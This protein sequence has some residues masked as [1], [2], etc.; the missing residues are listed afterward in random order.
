MI[1]KAFVNDHRRGEKKAV[2]F[3]AEIKQ[4]SD[5]LFDHS[6]TKLSQV[7]GSRVHR[8]FSA[9]NAWN[10]GQH[11]VPLRNASCTGCLTGPR[12]AARRS[13]RRQADRRDERPNGRVRR[14]EHFSRI[15]MESVDRNVYAPR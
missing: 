12:A 14:L 5:T 1:K 7:K 4:I 15:F 10:P 9:R 8:K 13:T 3:H 2:I 6:V 11:D